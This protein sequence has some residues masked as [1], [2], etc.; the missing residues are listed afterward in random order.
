MCDS[1]EEE[2]CAKG[3][4]PIF[5]RVGSKR[6]LVKKI[7]PLIPAH[8]VYVEPFIGGGAIY[9]AKC[10]SKKEVIND[11]D[12]DLIR[13]Y[14]LVKNIKSRDFPRDLNTLA[15][16]QP[17]YDHKQ[18][19]DA[20]K[21]TR[22]IIAR[23]NGF[24]GIENPKTLYKPANPYNKLK[25]IDEYQHRMRNTTILNK[26]YEVVMRHYDSPKAFFYLD[27]PYE[28]SEGLYKEG[29]MDFPKLAEVLRHIKG[30]WLMSINDSPN[31]RKLFKG[32]YAKGF[33]LK[34]VANKGIGAT[35]GKARKELLIANYSF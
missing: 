17:F 16:Q 2:K 22:A 10:A 31:I 13:D 12:S 15:K 7:L 19:T 33:T 1:C 25:H 21:L 6:S 11:L 30:K 14:R 35:G 27:P 18:T 9:W 28:A 3:L 8:D 32:F 29:G 34:T 5:C 20:N 23:C 4:K 26:S 24:G